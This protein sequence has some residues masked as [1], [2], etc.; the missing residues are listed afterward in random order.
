MGIMQGVL[1]AS[2]EAAKG[3]GAKSISEIRIS[4]GEL[5]EIQEFALQFAFEAMTPGTMAEG[6]KLSVTHVPATSKCNECGVE[7]AHD[8]FQMLCPE[9]DSFNVTPLTGRELLID[10]IE[11]EDLDATAPQSSSRDSLTDPDSGT[12]APPADDSEE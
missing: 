9:C 10:S 3:A 8:R 6:A 2:F 1:A 5:T 7:Y 12:G 11:T 4:I